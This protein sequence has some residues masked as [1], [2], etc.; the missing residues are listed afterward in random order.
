MIPKCFK[1]GSIFCARSD[2][3]PE[4]NRKVFIGM[5]FRAEFKNMYLAAIEPAL[6]HLNLE[7]WKAD[8]Q[9]NTIDIM[10]K[11]CGGI[12]ESSIAIIDISDW[13]PNVLFELGLIYGL[14]KT[15]FLIKKE[16]VEV[17]VDLSGLQYIPYGD[18]YGKLRED[19]IRY[20]GALISRNP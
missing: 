3:G 1:N 6:N 13:N 4:S 20:I 16:D 10:C 14:G 2:V 11:I 8:E 19:I 15:A 7:H 17:P 12:Q 5:P 18:D 9:F